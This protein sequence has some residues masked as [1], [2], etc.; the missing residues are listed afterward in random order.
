MSTISPAEGPALTLFPK[1]RR[2]ILGLLYSH[3]DEAYYLRQIIEL[4]GLAVGQV[5]RELKLLS[6]SGVLTRTQQGRHIY[7]RANTN[8]PIYTELRGIVRKTM[9]AVVVI[10]RALEPLAD[11]IRAAFIFGSVARAEETRA[12]DID[13]MVIGEA[14]FAEVADAVRSA[15]RSI[16]REINVTVYPV[17]E[18]G[19]KVAAGHHF[20][21]QV[22]SSEKLFV[23]GD[24]DEL[25]ALL[26]QP[27]D[28]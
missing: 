20:L 28:S 7:F 12:S 6:A 13:V 21:E 17:E 18:L 11:R 4:T 2:A 9:G 3:P 1:S 22:L 15:E 16:G 14:T 23:V 24:E 26:E 10:A 27:V 5:Q 25:A 8:C 19:A